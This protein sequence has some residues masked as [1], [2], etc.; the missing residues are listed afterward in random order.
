[1][2]VITSLSLRGKKVAAPS[3]PAFN[4][5]GIADSTAIFAGNK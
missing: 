5:E 2:V 1:L 4:G 3:V